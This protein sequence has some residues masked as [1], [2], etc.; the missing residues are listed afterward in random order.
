MNLKAVILFLM[1]AVRFFPA[2][3]MPV[4]S[5]VNDSNY[6][7]SDTLREGFVTIENVV[8]ELDLNAFDFIHHA[9]NVIQ[10]NG[11]DWTEIKH[12]YQNSHDG[13][14]SIVHIGDSHLQ[15]DIATGH[16]RALLQQ[17]HGDGGRG[18]I[19]PFRLAGTNEPVDYRLTINSKVKSSKLLKKPWVTPVN[20]CGIG[21]TPANKNFELIVDTEPHGESLFKF[22]RIYHS[23]KLKISGVRD[24]KDRSM[25]YWIDLMPDDNYT[26]VFLSRMTPSLKLSLSTDDSATIHGV[27]LSSEENGIIYHV[28]GNNG[29]CYSTY[30]ALADFSSGVS[31]LYPDLIIVSLGTNDAF[32]KLSSEDFYKEVDRLVTSLK[33]ENPE[34]KILLTTPKECQRGVRKGKSRKS[35]KT[36]VVVEN[37]H[38][39]RNVLLKY[40]R[41]HK[42]PVYD[43]FEV[44]G[45]DGASDLWIENS[46]L[47]KD[48]VHNTVAGYELAAIL[49]HS[50]LDRAL[51]S[52]LLVDVA[53]KD[54]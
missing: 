26:D 8:K 18:L 20:F 36:Y 29:A 51:S 30:N 31:T 13:N 21:V 45:G 40:G 50:A 1:L 28:I 49:F 23:G 6:I 15:A 43:W 35:P 27:M 5:L 7:D 33:K 38:K 47:N 44:A 11:D 19:V 25:E 37:C 42:I 52:S 4:D 9:A 53:L 17:D 16:V 24:L 22:I 41:D 2:A 14:F 3:Q 54:D 34:S 10:M 48:R 32:G 39:L 12:L 46:L